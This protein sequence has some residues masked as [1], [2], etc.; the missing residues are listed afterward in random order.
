[1][2]GGIRRGSDVVKALALGAKAVLLGRPMFWGLAC[3]GEQGL[4]DLL[5][6][7]YEEIEMVMMHCGRAD[8][9]SI[10]STVVAPAPSLGPG[11]SRG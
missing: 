7:L 9:A 8:I 10:D 1:M 11:G 5:D 6:L 3:D 2:D 4:L